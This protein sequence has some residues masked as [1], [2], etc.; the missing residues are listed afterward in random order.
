M[1][2]LHP[3]FYPAKD[4]RATTP[5]RPDPLH[6][7]GSGDYIN[8]VC[9]RTEAGIGTMIRI[10]GSQRGASGV[11]T[12]IL[13]AIA[14]YGVYVGIQYVP[15]LIESSSV[16]SILNSIEHEHKAEPIR[17]AQ[18][19]RAKVDNHLNINQLNHLKDSFSVREFGNEYIIEVSYERE[20]NLLYETRKIKHENSLTLH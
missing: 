5:P 14:A 12:V 6:G 4:R 9:S 15:Q 19:L 2:Q 8:G 20:L 7:P 1:A 16:G 13:L 10:S 17:S 3:L 11:G 18:A